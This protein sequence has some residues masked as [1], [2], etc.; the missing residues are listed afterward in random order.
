MNVRSLSFPLCFLLLW[1]TQTTLSGTPLPRTAVFAASQA[2]YTSHL[3]II[4]QSIV[5]VTVAGNHIAYG[6]NFIN[7]VDHPADSQQFAN[8]RLTGAQWNRWP[9]YWS[10][11]ETSAGVF[12]W[13]THDQVVQGDV[14][15]RFQTNAILLGTPSF[16]TTR[17]ATSLIEN[18]EPEPFGA[19]A[20]ADI[21]AATPQGLYEPIFA[22]GS[23]V[24]AANKAINP[25]NRWA[26]FVYT[27]VQRYKPNGVL[28]QQ[29][30]WASDQGITHWEMWNEADYV[31]FWDSSLA[32]YARLL[33]VGYLATKQAD[34]QAQV[35][36]GG[37][38]NNGNRD[39]Y[40]DVLAI[41]A[42]DALAADHGFYHDIFATHNYS[43]AWESWYW[44]WKASAAQ[45]TH[46]LDKEIWLNETGVPAW[47][48]YPGP[49]WD[50]KSGLRGTTA[51]QTDFLIQSAFYALY[52]GVDGF[53]H[54]QLYDGCGNQPA[55]TD[56]PPHNSELCDSNGKL[57]SDS[58][59]PCAGDANGLFTNP[60]D[61]ICFSQHPT[62]ETGRPNL[63]AYQLLT[64]HVQDVVPLWRSR[65]GGST[66][67]DGTLELI[68]LHQPAT[69]KRLIGMW[70][71]SGDGETAVIDA[72]ST[73]ALLLGADGSQQTITPINGQYTIVLPGATNQNAFWD[74]SLYMIGGKTYVLIE[75]MP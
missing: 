23:D 53:F 75:D 17:H 59:K 60:S 18:D 44:V 56:F 57:I 63:A 54:F 42:T 7:S 1:L 65:P 19:L 73:Q 47:D 11:I 64:T 14:S 22:D 49:T 74:P 20:L 66:P 40:E 68:A 9:L 55:F 62:P 69:N 48:D 10:R 46:N 2:T 58:S 67:Y 32:D 21:Q 27:I 36:F 30:N 6:V 24:P 37:L 51:E 71:R 26:Y 72:T 39:F 45:S 12:D 3:P 15:N 50:S 70:S 52:A 61:A 31:I 43:Y 13:T 5:P 16:Y 34:S 41:Y 25:D 8:G 35:L 33:K 28:A 29:N 38:A 4:H